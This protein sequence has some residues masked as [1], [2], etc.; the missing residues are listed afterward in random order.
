MK[1]F[2]SSMLPTKISVARKSSVLYKSS[3]KNAKKKSKFGSFLGIT[4]L[5][6][7]FALFYSVIPFI[8]VAY[9]A[10]ILMNVFGELT[11]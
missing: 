6:C 11:P 4:L 3:L 9:F 10:R 8:A 2:K 7:I 1:P 5:L